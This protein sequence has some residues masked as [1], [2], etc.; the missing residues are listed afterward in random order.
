MSETSTQ[1]LAVAF[2]LKGWTYAQIGRKLGVSRQ[3]AQ[4]LVRPPKAVYDL[5]RK[6]AGGCCQE[7]GVEVGSGQV[8]PEDF[9]DVDGLKYLCVAC[10]VKAH[11][12]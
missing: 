7:C 3:R 10:H 6:R 8:H 11:G 2:K 9:N 12:M 5:V 1:A 4:Q